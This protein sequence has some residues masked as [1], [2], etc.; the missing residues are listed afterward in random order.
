MNPT[1]DTYTEMRP[2]MADFRGCNDGFTGKEKACFSPVGS[3]RWIG[4]KVVIVFC[5]CGSRCHRGTREAHHTQKIF[6]KIF[7]RHS[8][9]KS[10]AP[11]GET[12]RTTMPTSSSCSRRGNRPGSIRKISRPTGRAQESQY[13]ANKKDL[14]TLGGSFSTARGINDSGQIVANSV[15]RQAYLLTPVPSVVPIPAALPLFASALIGFGLMGYRRRKAQ[16]V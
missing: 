9:D 16:A 6:S 4:Q 11:A 2:R 14:G 7:L 12:W 3:P 8:G 10:S 5:D 15:G 13:P 1:P